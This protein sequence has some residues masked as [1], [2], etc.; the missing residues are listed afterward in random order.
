LKNGELIPVS[1]RKRSE[2]LEMLDKW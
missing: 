1:V 2:V